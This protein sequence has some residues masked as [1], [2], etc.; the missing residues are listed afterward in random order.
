MKQ[1]SSQIPKQEPIEPEKKVEVNKIQPVL[2]DKNKVF[3]KDKTVPPISDGKNKAPAMDSKTMPPNTELPKN[4][5]KMP[6]IKED[7]KTESKAPL[8]VEKKGAWPD[9]KMPEQVKE[10]QKKQDNNKTPSNGVNGTA[11]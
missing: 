11:I 5:S 10:S 8:Q 3:I 4:G 6:E 1:S 7:P 9:Q 2:D